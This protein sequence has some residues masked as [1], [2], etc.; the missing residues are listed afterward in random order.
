[1]SSEESKLVEFAL[2]FDGSEE[3]RLLSP[4]QARMYLKNLPGQT[5]ES[6]FYIMSEKMEP[7]ELTTY[8]DLMIINL[9]RLKAQSKKRLSAYRRMLR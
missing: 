8:I 9:K 4:P 1:M 7:T 6:K 5:E 2:E 3:Q